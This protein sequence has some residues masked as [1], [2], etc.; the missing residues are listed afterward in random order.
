MGSPRPQPPTDPNAPGAGLPRRDFVGPH[1]VPA[2]ARGASGVPCCRHLSRG[3][4]AIPERPV[5]P[6]ERLPGVWSSADHGNEDARL[7]GCE[8]SRAAATSRQSAT[9]R[10]A[11]VRPRTALE[12]RRPMSRCWQVLAPSGGFGWR[13]SPASALPA[14]PCCS[15]ARGCSAPASASVVPRRSPLGVS[16]SPPIGEEPRGLGFQGPPSPSV[17]SA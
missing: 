10:T 14:G 2:R 6:D 11:D 15:S 16:G 17:I 3:A 13:V 7:S 8:F 1:A 12:P 4:C 9:L 5:S